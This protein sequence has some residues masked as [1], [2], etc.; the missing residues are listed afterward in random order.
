MLPHHPNIPRYHHHNH[1]VSHQE[2]PLANPTTLHMP[3]ASSSLDEYVHFFPA[4]MYQQQPPQQQ[5]TLEAVL[6]QPVTAP[7]PAELGEPAN[8]APGGAVVGTARK[9]PFRTDRH[10]KIHTAQGVRDRRM[11]LSVGVARD[12][13]ALQD[14]LGFDKASKTVD[15]LLTQSKP[16]I[17]R[18]ADAAPG[19]TAAAPRAS[20]VREKGDGASSSSTDCFRD[21]RAHASDRMKSAGGDSSSVVLMADRGGGRQVD[22][23]MSEAPAAAAAAIEQPMEGLDYYYQYYQLEEMMSAATTKEY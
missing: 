2:P 20:S 3:P 9:R 1:C 11:R 6:W 23:L 12:F 15:W 16:A 4:E 10:S 5:E 17:E 21:A 14:L 18:L 22:W 19:A 7:V 8:R 13:F